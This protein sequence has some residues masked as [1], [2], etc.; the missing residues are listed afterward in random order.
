MKNLEIFHAKGYSNRQ[1]ADI[2]NIYIRII[3]IPIVNK[4]LSTYTIPEMQYKIRS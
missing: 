3:S 2:L 1:I 4:I